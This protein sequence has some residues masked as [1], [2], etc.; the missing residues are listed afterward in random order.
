MISEL[1]LL[2]GLQAHA[3]AVDAFD[4]PFTRPPLVVAQAAVSPDQ[5]AAMARKQTGGR[6]LGVDWGDNGGQPVYMVRVLMPDG[7]I[8]VVAIP[9]SG[10]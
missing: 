8:R 6:V 4:H 3:A 9:A 10:K 7:S 2:A 1:L 5:A